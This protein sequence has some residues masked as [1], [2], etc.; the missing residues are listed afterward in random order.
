[1]NFSTALIFLLTVL[2]IL[3]Y[4][5]QK[6]HEED[7]GEQKKSS[8]SSSSSDQQLSLH[9]EEHDQRKDLSS[10]RLLDKRCRC[11]SLAEIKLATNDF[12]DAFVIGKG[13]FGK[14]YKGKIDFGEE[15]I[16]VAIK[17]L[18]LDSNQGVTEFKA[19][20]EMLSKFR[21]SH[22]VSL[23]GYHEGSD[24]RE[25]IIVYEYM[26]NGSLED[27]LHKRKV[28]G[29]N[30][31]LLTWVQTLQI[32]IGAARGLDYLHS[33]TGV[34]SRVIHR[35]IKSSN[36]L[37]DENLAA[38]VSD[39][40]L[41]RIG[42][43][44][45]VGTTNVYTDQIKGTFGY[46]DAEYFSTCRLTRKSDVYAFGVVLLEVLCGRPA[47]DFTLDEQ[48]HSLAVWAKSCIKEGKIDQI[49]DQC[50]KG[51]TT[52]NCVKEFG[53]IAY[54]CVLTRSKDRPTMSQV[55]ARLEFVLAWTLQSGPSARDR[56]Q[57]GR[58]MF[59][60]KAWS[61]FLIKSPKS[62]MSSPTKKLGQSIYNKK[63]SVATGSQK[64]LLP[65]ANTKI[66]ILKMFTFSELQSATKNFK[67]EMFLGEGGYGKVYKGWLDSVTFAPRK[68]GDGLAVA[69]K[70][71]SPNRTQGLNEWQAEVKF[72]GT[73]SHPNI[74][75]LFGYCWENKEFLLVY[76]F[77]QKGSLDMQLF[78]E[79]VEPL[80]W[81]TRIKIA[82]GAAQ[83]LAFLHTTENNVICRDVKSSNI[84]LDGEFNAKL[85]D[86]GLAKSGPVKGE[87][88]VST[89]IAG[90]Y[91]YMAPE[92][93]ATGRLYVK[94]DVY[95]FGVLMLEIIT[96]LRASDY[97]QD[98]MKQ[99]L[100]E[101]A[102]PFL[103]DI[104]KLEKIMDPRLGQ[105]YPSEGA[106]K[107]AE[108]ILSCLDSDPKNRPSMEE[109]V[110]GLQVI[111][112]VKM[113]PGRSTSSTRGSMS[114]CSEQSCPWSPLRGK[115]GRA[116][117]S[118]STRLLGLNVCLGLGSKEDR[119]WMETNCS[120]TRKWGN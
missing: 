71:S 107:A 55:V 85:S 112:S 87:S 1:M 35:D 50:L 34:R 70:R 79:G 111:G 39:F 3:V 99:N 5:L 80:P 77:M 11:F 90:T 24:K 60:E 72:L 84:L 68:P 21:H 49:I 61:L 83:G 13:G 43:A 41:S 15:G 96:G 89:D 26:P 17:R 75:K 81:D 120:K 67:Q 106:S 28:N 95:G 20:I 105:N 86:F 82:T 23:L 40:G 12:D 114:P 46:M 64:V 52:G 74:V 66:P 57:I 56:K 27:H 54:E 59:I 58:A 104:K 14:V 36:I 73:F 101:W 94:S 76:E 115:Q 118:M 45:L 22:I 119:T 47:L 65:N 16:D 6:Q 51:Q 32:C 63:T 109:V 19:E 62:R 4:Y 25:M 88:H 102:T 117:W 33:G 92:Y 108:L 48:Q 110:L 9:E 31:S 93:I 30:S 2:D 98:G 91:G 100:V 8:L 113:E 38:K 37:L 97:N 103:T 7:N 44:N 53:R 10:S 29:S 18:N 42:P 78:R 69:I 116:V